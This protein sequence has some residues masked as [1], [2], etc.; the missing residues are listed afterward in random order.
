MYRVVA[1]VCVDNWLKHGLS[2]S[3]VQLFYVYD[4]VIACYSNC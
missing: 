4:D 3:S 1:C 2:R